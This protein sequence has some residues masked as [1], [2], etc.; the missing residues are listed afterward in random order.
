MRK[1]RTCDP[2]KG[3]IYANNKELIKIITTSLNGDEQRARK[4]SKNFARY[5]FDIK[6][7]KFVGFDELTRNHN[8]NFFFTPVGIEV[9]LDAESIQ[10]LFAQRG[11]Q[12]K[13]YELITEDD[14]RLIKGA[15]E[16]VTETKKVKTIAKKHLKV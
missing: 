9:I 13:N 8:Y 2:S 16:E 15:L 11:T 4:L 3:I 7:F 12:Y 14:L 10:V 6:N 5:F 1:E